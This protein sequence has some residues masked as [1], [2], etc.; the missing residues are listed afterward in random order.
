MTLS[1]STQ[2]ASR[3]PVSLFEAVSANARSRVGILAALLG[4]AFLAPL[5]EYDSGPVCTFSS[6]AG[7]VPPSS[8]PR[9]RHSWKFGLPHRRPPVHTRWVLDAADRAPAH[10]RS[11]QSERHR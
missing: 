5:L 11:A 2:V 7:N 3:A 9:A 4:G 8:P 10:R 6:R 1:S